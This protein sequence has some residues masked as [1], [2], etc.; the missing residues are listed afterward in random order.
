ML[1]NSYEFILC[2]LPITAIIYFGL[3]R[4]HSIKLAVYWLTLASIA[5]YGYWNPAYVPL[6][7]V[8]VAGNFYFGRWLNKAPSKAR[9]KLLL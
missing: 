3:I 2:F 6:L 8:S 4:F 9:A 7:L 5:F 1:F